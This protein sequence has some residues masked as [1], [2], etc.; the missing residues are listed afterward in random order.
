MV[1]KY[2]NLGG[3]DL[4]FTLS[5]SKELLG[6]FPRQYLGLLNRTFSEKRKIIQKKKDLNFTSRNLIQAWVDYD[7]V[8]NPLEEEE[9]AL[10]EAVQ[11]LDGYDVRNYNG[12]S[13]GDGDGRSEFEGHFQSSAALTDIFGQ[14]QYK[15]TWRRPN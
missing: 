6:A 14:A 9:M 8:K 15:V 1:T 12:S 4:A 13:G 5:T 2:R 3:H 10:S 7:P 11:A